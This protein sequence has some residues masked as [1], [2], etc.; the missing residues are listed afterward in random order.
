[1]HIAMVAV[2]LYEN[3]NLFDLSLVGAQVMSVYDVKFS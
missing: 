3:L 1:M 2:I